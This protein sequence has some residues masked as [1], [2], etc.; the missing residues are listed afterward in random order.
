[1]LLEQMDFP[2]VSVALA[3]DQI[4]A[5]DMSKIEPLIQVLPLF[6]TVYHVFDVLDKRN[7][8][9]TAKAPREV[10]MR[11][12]TSTRREYEGQGLMKKLAGFLMR[13]AKEQGFRA[14]NIEAL[15]DAVSHVW[16]NPPKPFTSELV[17]SI[18]MATYEEVVDGQTVKPFVP[19]KK[20]GMKIYVTL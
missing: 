18:D 5:L 20:V 14:I 11:N 2:L 12:A 19:S 16:L 10:L 1:M 4:N 8:S 17:S 7:K 9:W 6:G 3:Y 15:N 13:E